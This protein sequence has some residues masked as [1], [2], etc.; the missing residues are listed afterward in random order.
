MGPSQLKAVVHLNHVTPPGCRGIAG[1]HLHNKDS[2]HILDWEAHTGK[3]IQ[4]EALESPSLRITLLYCRFTRVPF[5]RDQFHPVLFQC[6]GELIS[7][8]SK[9]RSDSLW[10]A[11]IPV[12]SYTQ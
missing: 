7:L 1:R 9:R 5:S 2:V 12:A 4:G 8:S 3:R 10:G 11:K 6:S